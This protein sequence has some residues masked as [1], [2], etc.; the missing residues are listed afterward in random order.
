MP[1]FDFERPREPERARMLLQQP[2]AVPLGGGTDLLVAVREGIASPRTLVDLRG[3]PGAGELDFRADGSLWIGATARLARIAAD[4]RVRERFPALATACE[5]VGSV[6]LRNMATLGGNL[7]QRPRCSYFRIGVPCFKAGGHGCPAVDGENQLHAVLG[8]GP[9]HAVHPSDPAVALSALEAALHV[10]G[11]NG[12]RVVPIGEFFV[13][14]RERVTSETVLEAGELVVG[15]ELPAHS[16][17]GRQRYVKL[18]QRGGW[19]FALASLA[20]VRRRDGAVR[21]VLGGLA[22]V[23]WRVNPSV[24][25]DVA[26]GALA[27][28]DLDTLAE[29]ALHDARPLA[30]NAYKI[31]LAKT[32]LRDGMRFASS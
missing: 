24:E 30:K 18:M 6:A 11:P 3:I 27:D 13:L 29:R 16:S 23:P 5:A 20:A 31:V 26:S 17:G 22:T 9:C 28:D 4:G 19:D 1:A 12:V 8:G 15:I 32:L 14:P 21:L 25:E 10:V 7:C 2:G